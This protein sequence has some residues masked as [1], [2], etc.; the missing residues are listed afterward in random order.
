MRRHPIKL[1][2][3]AL[4][5]LSAVFLASGA[6]TTPAIS[7]ETTKSVV[8]AGGCFW[9]VESDFDKVPGVK[10]TISGYAGG[11][12][13]NPTYRSVTYGSAG[14]LEVVKVVYDPSVVSFARLTEIFWRSIDPTDASGQFCDKGPSYRSAIFVS[15]D[16]ERKI[17]ERQKKAIEASGKL[18][19]PIATR[20]LDDGP[21]Y[22]AEDYHQ[23]FYTKNPL[24]YYS[25]RR[26]CRRDIRVKQLWGDDSWGGTPHS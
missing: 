26:G 8:L 25:Y 1:M 10:E 24:R 18:P 16:A 5:T 23:D 15:N 17:V 9:C 3:I 13:K 7:G 14:H 22:P 20:I 21:F 12:T 11:T 4:A 6:T 19:G 2:S